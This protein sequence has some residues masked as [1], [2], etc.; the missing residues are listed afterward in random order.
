M[1]SFIV[2]KKTIDRV[3]SALSDNARLREIVRDIGYDIDI[4]KGKDR[5]GQD[6][7]ALNV[8]GYNERYNANE[9]VPP[10]IYEH[11]S[12]S[13]IQGLKSLRC[14]LYQATE[15]DVP[16]TRLYQKMLQLSLYWASVI[17]QNLPEYD[18]AEWG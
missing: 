4:E 16:E 9:T 10:Y 12:T 5:L 6:L 11:I 7:W 8:R 3:I 13:Q 18:N 17:V 2:E 15:G 14:I 1:S